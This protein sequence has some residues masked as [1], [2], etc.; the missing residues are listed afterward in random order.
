MHNLHLRNTKFAKIYISNFLHKIDEYCLINFAKIEFYQLC[1][2]KM[3]LQLLVH[4]LYAYMLYYTYI[5]LHND[6]QS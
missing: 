1:K 6:A 3:Y 5:I 4:L 2:P